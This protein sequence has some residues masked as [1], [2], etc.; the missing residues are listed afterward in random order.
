MITIKL[1]MQQYSNI[2]RQD[3]EDVVLRKQVGKVLRWV[4]TNNVT[5][6]N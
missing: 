1:N 4:Y 6:I 5:V 3:E 2:Y